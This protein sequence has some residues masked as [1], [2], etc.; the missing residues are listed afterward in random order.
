MNN[1]RCGNWLCLVALF[2]FISAIGLGCER[3]EGDRGLLVSPSNARL[4]WSEAITFTATLPESADSDR[5]VLY[6]LEWSVSDPTMGS[7]RSAG[8]DSVV[9]VAGRRSG[10]N[11]VVVRD[12]GGAEGVA[13]ITQTAPASSGDGN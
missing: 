9:Y 5:A 7:L 1:N 13:S 4:A 12:Q 10:A 6:P 8:G 11:S 3:V 2:G